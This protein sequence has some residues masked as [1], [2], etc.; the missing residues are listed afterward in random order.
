MSIFRQKEINSSN[1]PLG[2]A[3]SS[4]GKSDTDLNHRIAKVG[5]DFWMS[6]S[7][8][9]VPA[10]TPQAGCPGP[11]PGRFWTSPWRSPHISLVPV[12]QQSSAV[13]WAGWAPGLQA[14]PRASMPGSVLLHLPAG[15]YWHGWDPPKLLLLQ[16]EQPQLSQSLL[17][18]ERFHSLQLIG[19]PLLDSFQFIQVSLN[20][21]TWQIGS[22][23]GSLICK[24]PSLKKRRERGGEKEKIM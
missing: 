16:A 4:S 2:S 8:N 10:G 14:V 5:S 18:V 19:G 15:I 6:F 1:W 9:S 20:E 23:L 13:W 21:V 3:W 11:H 22:K 17:T 24:K 7:P 12:T